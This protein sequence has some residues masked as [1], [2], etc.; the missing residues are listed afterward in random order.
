MELRFTISAII[1]TTTR[2]F[3]IAAIG[4]IW[5]DQWWVSWEWASLLNNY[6]LLLGWIDNV[7]VLNKFITASLGPLTNHLTISILV[8]LLFFFLSDLLP[9]NIKLALLRFKS[10]G[11]HIR[12]IRWSLWVFTPWLDLVLSYFKYT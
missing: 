9:N 11:C 12:N 3:L 10:T 8:I 7:S 6:L 1:E 2:I 5:R 4:L